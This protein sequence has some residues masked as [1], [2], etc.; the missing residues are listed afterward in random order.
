MG[1]YIYT[2]YAQTYGKRV[3]IIKMY[4]FKIVRAVARTTLLISDR[5]LRSEFLKANNL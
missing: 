1:F 2:H 4:I 5:T 3:N